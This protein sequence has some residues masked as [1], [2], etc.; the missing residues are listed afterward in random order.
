MS[1]AFQLC[2]LKG[3]LWHHWGQQLALLL[4]LGGSLFQVAEDMEPYLHFNFGNPSS[5]HYYGTP[6]SPLTGLYIW[7]TLSPI[8]GS[9]RPGQT[10][11][12]H[13]KVL[14]IPSKQPLPALQRSAK[15]QWSWH[16]KGWQT[17]WVQAPRRST[18]RPAAQSRTTGQSGERSWLP[19][20]AVVE[21][22]LPCRCCSQHLH[23]DAAARSDIYMVYQH[24]S[25][26][27]E[28]V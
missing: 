10:C 8:L 24:L 12:P 7:L 13:N 19:G 18:L 3:V 1:V 2:G 4:I 15:P 16:G 9:H 25:S 27:C 5:S 23:M 20:T 17:W 22:G 26:W 14:W 6:A 28:P 11:F 21:G